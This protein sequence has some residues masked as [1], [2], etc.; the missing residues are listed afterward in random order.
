MALVI[1]RKRA[2]PVAYDPYYARRQYAR[3]L[4]RRRIGER[5]E[6]MMIEESARQLRGARLGFQTVPRSRGIYAAGEMKYFDSHLS[7]AT[8]PEGNDWTSTELDPATLLTLFAPSEGPAINQRIGRKVNVHKISVKGMIV[9]STLADQADPVASSPVRLVLVQDTQTN[10]TQL[11]GE[12][13][14]AA[15]GAANSALVVS[16]F[17][18]LAQSGRFK[19]LKDKIL[20]HPVPLCGTD[21]AN[22]VSVSQNPIVF[23]FTYKFATPVVVRF[24]ATNGGTIADIVDNS[25]H[26]LGTKGGTTFTSG[27]SYAARTYY[28]E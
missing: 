2:R 4:K 21:G 26:M 27:I 3:G 6:E 1:N 23:K 10:A 15:P 7:G 14:F 25:W 16:S 22:T 24:N 19:I 9:S 5:E 28:K 12:D 13:V 11:S 18:S 20:I 17:Q 8:V